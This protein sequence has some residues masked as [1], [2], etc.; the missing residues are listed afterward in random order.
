MQA[1][2]GGGKTS[3]P[4]VSGYGVLLEIGDVMDYYMGFFDRSYV[5][6]TWDVYKK[7]KLYYHTCSV[8][9]YNKSKPQVIRESKIVKPYYGN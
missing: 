3:A 9:K 7:L 5:S 4:F 6:Y 8:L 1:A 2:I